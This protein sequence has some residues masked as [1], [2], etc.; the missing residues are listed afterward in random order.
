MANAMG[1]IVWV[2]RKKIDSPFAPPLELAPQLRS[3]PQGRR[4][5]RQSNMSQSIPPKKDIK[6]NAMR[7][8]EPLKF[9]GVSILSLEWA[10]AVKKPDP[11]AVASAPQ[12]RSCC[13]SG[14]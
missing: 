3:L 2:P 7:I 10:A 12:L 1:N 11:V 4:A 8:H 9:A 5:Y 13:V 14:W 6:A